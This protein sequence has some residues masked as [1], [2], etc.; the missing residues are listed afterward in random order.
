M[1]KGITI[2]A[3]TSKDLDDAVWVEHSSD[4]WGVYVTIADVAARIKRGS[5][6][7]DLAYGRVESRY[8]SGGHTKSM[9]PEKIENG[10]SLLEGEERTGLCIKIYLDERLRPTK[11]PFIRS[12]RFQSRKRFAYSDIPDILSDPN[13]EWHGQ[14]KL[15][16]TLATGLMENRRSRGAFVLYDLNAGWVTTEE[17]AL[18]R[19]KDTTETIG[20][21]IIQELMILA[22]AEVSRLCAEKEI[23]VP[24]RNHT[25]KPHAPDRASLM[26]QIH[27][28]VHKPLT[29]VD[30]LRQTAHM[31]MNRAEYGAALG[32]HYG[33][34]LPAYVHCTSPIRRYAD[35]VTQRQLEAWVA[36]EALPYTHEEVDEICQHINTRTQALRDK[37]SDF[38]KQLAE[39]KAK[40]TI[41]TE[42][43]AVLTHREFERVTKVLARGLA[44][45][46]AFAEEFRARLFSDALPIVNMHTILVEAPQ[47]DEG[48]K[49]L[50]QSVIDYLADSPHQGVSVATLCQALSGWWEVQY[51]VRQ[52]GP[53]HA[54]Q[55]EVQA[56]TLLGG[57]IYKSQKVT[58]S[59]SK[60]AKQRACVDVLAL[61]C[62][63][64]QPSWPEV[65]LPKA[66]SKAVE[67]PEPGNNPI[68]A[69]Q[70]Y[71]Q[72]L[73]VP[74][75]EY[76]DERI[77]GVDHSPK[78][79]MSCSFQ[80]QTVISI[81]TSSKKAAK[82]DAAR[83][84]L[85][86]LKR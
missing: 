37:D 1:I 8:F 7:D 73:A 77:G 5:P 50:R 44:F 19:L 74:L 22:N 86:E 82:K 58:T 68:S 56:R 6:F 25:A 34:N 3:P 38:F 9:L 78:F 41:R 61:V 52:R 47:D 65:P 84:M 60:L 63:L 10:L 11:L 62:G 49:S 31:T 16:S 17:G 75:P 66:E 43:F 20:Y 48:W 36:G 46:E 76:K 67:I 12:T 70:E 69:L 18:R 33:L 28:A 30:R 54:P 21:I 27:A 57:T 35:L 26:E 24:W 23:P 45:N 64:N 53:D 72:A 81:P 15:L 39:G 79:K 29:D 4:D 2:D 59:S 80:G 42:D 13:H 83:R 51:K 32:G 55:H 71:A 40:G 85:V 14:M